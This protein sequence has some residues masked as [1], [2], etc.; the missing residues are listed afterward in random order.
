MPR[1]SAIGHDFM[2]LG[3]SIIPRFV[4]RYGHRL[5]AEAKKSPTGNADPDQ[6]AVLIALSERR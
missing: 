4:D 5:V 2:M 6:L 3:I 1:S